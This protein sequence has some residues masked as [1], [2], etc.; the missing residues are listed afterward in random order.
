MCRRSVVASVVVSLY[1]MGCA[2]WRPASGTPQELIARESPSKVRLTR[3]DSA[4]IVVVHPRVEDDAV[5][6]LSLSKGGQWTDSI[7]VPA[8]DIVSIE[9]QRTQW[10]L[11][12]GI[13]AGV[14][15][16]LSAISL[17]GGVVGN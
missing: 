8:N 2:E 3:T 1:L 12:L 14:L 4:R 15:V 9:R 17:G 16:I 13:G 6:G 11:P 7:R 10:L 5:L